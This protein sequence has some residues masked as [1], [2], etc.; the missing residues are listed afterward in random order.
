MTG[1]KTRIGLGVGLAVALA[2]VTGLQARLATDELVR[3]CDLVIPVDR[4]PVQ[5]EPIAVSVRHSASFGDTVLASLP[6]AS[7]IRVVSV[8]HAGKE[9]PQ[10]LRVT[11]NTSQAVAGSYEL[12][13]AD[14]QAECRGTIRVGEKTDG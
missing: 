14:G 12:T 11:L 8:A 10:T 9:E 1:L 7:K 4:V 5:A 13:V 6:A 2:G 3:L